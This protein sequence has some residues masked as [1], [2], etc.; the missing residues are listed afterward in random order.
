MFSSPFYFFSPSVSHSFYVYFQEG[1]ELLGK[2][3]LGDTR[4]ETS[5]RNASKPTPKRGVT[6]AKTVEEGTC[7]LQKL[8]IGWGGG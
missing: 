3:K 4:Q 1:K 6:I 5:K 7:K 2:E 8:L